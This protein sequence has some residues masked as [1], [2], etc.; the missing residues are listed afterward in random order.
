VIG[1]GFPAMV[2]APAGQMFPTMRSFALELQSRGV[3]LLIISNREELL[4]IATTP[5]PLP[6]DMMEW[7]SPIVVVVSGQMF[8]FPLTVLKGC[9]PDHPE[10]LQKVTR[11]R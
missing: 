1:S 2:I 10:G 3:K 4:S 6:T 9:D 8:A 11:T 7:L 5:L